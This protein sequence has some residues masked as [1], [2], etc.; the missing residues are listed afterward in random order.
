ME[1]LSFCCPNL[2]LVNFNCTSMYFYNEL[3]IYIENNL[4]KETETRVGKKLQ[5]LFNY[6][7]QFDRKR[8]S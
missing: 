3:F 2:T 1:E 8:N 6:E 4:I 7:F 5:S